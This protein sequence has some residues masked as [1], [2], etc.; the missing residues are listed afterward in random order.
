MFLRN[1]RR[2][3][4]VQGQ[5][6]ISEAEIIEVNSSLFV[7]I[8]IDKHLTWKPHIQMVNKC[9]ETEFRLIWDPCNF[10]TLKF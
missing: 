4:H 3:I 9:I 5:L 1:Q 10:G 8:N 7:G 2:Q 6:A